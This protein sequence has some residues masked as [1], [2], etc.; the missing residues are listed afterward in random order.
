MP[1]LITIPFDHEHMTAAEL[2]DDCWG[3]LWRYGGAKSEE[4]AQEK[5]PV[6]S[7]PLIFAVFAVADECPC[8]CRRFIRSDH[9]DD[10]KLHAQWEAWINASLAKHNYGEARL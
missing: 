10:C 6:L 3:M 9:P 5:Y 8:C 7:Q 1:L 4:E 2:L